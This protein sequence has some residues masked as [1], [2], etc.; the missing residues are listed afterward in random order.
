MLTLKLCGGG[1]RF[2]KCRVD[3]EEG[4]DFRH[5]HQ[6]DHLSIHPDEAERSAGLLSRDLHAYEC[7]EA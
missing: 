2:L 7:S 5:F 3:L 1:F 6:S 4:S